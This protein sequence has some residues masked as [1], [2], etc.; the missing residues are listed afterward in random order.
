MTIGYRLPT[1]AEWAW[2][3]RYDGGETA[4]KYPWGDSLPVAAGSGNYADASALGFLPGALPDYHDKFP[5]TSPVDSFEPNAR[6]LYN[7]SG[8][9]AEWAHDPYAIRLGGSS[10]VER[11]PLG[12]AE[13]DH[14]VIRGSSWMHSTV[15]ELRLTFRD[16]GSD[17]RPDLGFRVAR[18]SQ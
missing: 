4:L 9:V 13:G 17:A 2:A 10:K 5:V 18:Y 15:T 16:Y 14:H 7:L 3:T 11:D 8:N 12:P 1:E 6:G